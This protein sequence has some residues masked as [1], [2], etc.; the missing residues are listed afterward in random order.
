MLGGTS[1]NSRP[2]FLAKRPLQEIS[3]LPKPHDKEALD[4]IVL[5]ITGIQP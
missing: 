3:L 4:L 2:R 5:P 1:K